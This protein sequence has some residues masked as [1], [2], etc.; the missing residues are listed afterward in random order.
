MEVLSFRVIL[1][2]DDVASFTSAESNLK[3][4]TYATVNEYSAERIL[5]S[6]QVFSAVFMNP[7]K[8]QL[9]GT[10]LIRSIH[11]H[12]P[13]VPIY[14]V[15]NGDQNI[16]E[17]MELQN[18]AI[19]KVI[20]KP[21]T[22]QMLH[23]ILS[24]L[25]TKFSA[26]EIL[27]EKTIDE[28]M[29]DTDFTPTLA[30]NYISGKVSYFDLF[31]R[32]KNGRY[33][34][35]FNVGDEFDPGRI[36]RYYKKGVQYFYIRKSAQRHYLQ[37]C[38]TLVE[39]LLREA[40]MP[41]LIKTRQVMNVGQETVKYLNQIGI[42]E[43]SIKK[44]NQ[45]VKKQIYVIKDMKLRLTEDIKSFL[46]DVTLYEHGVATSTVA[47][48]LSEA[49]GFQSDHIRR[50]ISIAGLFHDIGLIKQEHEFTE[51]SHPHYSKSILKKAKIDDPLILSAVEEHHERRDGTGFPTGLKAGLIAPLAEI[52]GISDYFVHLIVQAKEDNTVN[53]TV[54]IRDVFNWYSYTTITAFEKIFL[55]KS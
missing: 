12:M 38:D 13:G 31:I 4:K 23:E 42:D 6:K 21:L 18:L 50:A 53:P 52:I 3:I 27:Q 17:E 43:S 5:A 37:F 2:D 39:K 19:Q 35:L 54:K 11:H 20:K 30:M 26:E 16:Y 55:R 29:E 32:S 46:N 24:P 8:F 48:L 49:M 1:F 28:K 51:L 34:K 36:E 45:Y 7:E 14:F 10:K 47:L 40:K 33:F 22:Y 9:K 15:V 25:T 44:V 41:S